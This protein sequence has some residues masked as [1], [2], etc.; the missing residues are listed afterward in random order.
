[1]T[2]WEWGK[3]VNLGASVLVLKFSYTVLPIV[4]HPGESRDPWFNNFDPA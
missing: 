1:M 3:V 4:V 2:E